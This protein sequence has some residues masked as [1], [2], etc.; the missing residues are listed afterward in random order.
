MKCICPYDFI[1]QGVFY[2][3]LNITTRLKTEDQKEDG[4][5]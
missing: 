4:R 2:I 5:S 3:W 1:E